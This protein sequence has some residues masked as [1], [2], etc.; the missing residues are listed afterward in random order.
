MKIEKIMIALLIIV[1]GVNFYSALQERERLNVGLNL[2]DKRI[3]QAEDNI[4]KANE[5][6]GNTLTDF[7]NMEYILREDIDF[8]SSELARHKHEKIYIETKEE[9]K[10]VEKT[11][12]PAVE[13]K[14]E[15]TVI[16]KEINIERIYDPETNL[17]VPNIETIPVNP[18][19]A[20][21][22]RA[23]N[24][25]NK[26]ISRLNIRRD[27]KFVVTYD[28]ID[29]EITNARF[30]NLVPAN[31]KGAVIKFIDSFTRDGDVKDCKISIKVLEN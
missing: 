5:Y 23:N 24:K 13:I 15:P 29:D 9:P 26:Y 27:Y 10:P 6:I 17:H 1:F 4:N 25:L 31:L 11:E 22:P 14:T 21:C 7:D 19:V 2:L 16:N 20:S 12:V 3:N 18:V 8:V 28:I 30:N